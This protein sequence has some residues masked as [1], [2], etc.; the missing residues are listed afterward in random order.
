MTAS[1]NLGF[2]QRTADILGEEAS[3]RREKAILLEIVAQTFAI[4]GTAV[5]KVSLG[6]FLLRLLQK[7]V[8]KIAVWSAMGIL[9]VLALA[10][11]FVLWFQVRALDL[12]IW[13]CGGG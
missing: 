3:G 10:T 11:C 12:P 1:A 13:F 2:G 4:L 6:L 7:R 5:A 8:Y 9:A